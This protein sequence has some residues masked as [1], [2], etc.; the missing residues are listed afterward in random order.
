VSRPAAGGGR[1]VSVDPERLPAWL[2]GFAARHGA[3][4]WHAGPE[5][6]EVR[7]A[8]GALAVCEV[9]LPPLTVDPDE[10]WGGLPAHALAE[11]TV[12]VLLV[13]LGGFAAGVFAGSRLVASRTGSRPVHGRAAA[14][15]WSQRRFARRR[16]GQARVALDAAAEAA[17]AVLLP[18][19]DTLHALVGGGDRR[20]VEAVLADA[21]LASLRP[22]LS[23]RL[24]DVPDPRRRVLEDAPRLFRAVSIRVVDG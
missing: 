4:E 1:W 14:G 9:P 24:L 16:E 17:A 12:G 19:A 15:G 18:A 11:W 23:P 5:R 3:V 6:V 10:P 8:D 13:R 2:D 20:A 21:R 22:L 7:A